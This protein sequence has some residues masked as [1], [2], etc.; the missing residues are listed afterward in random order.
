MNAPVGGQSAAAV[1]TGSHRITGSRRHWV[2]GGVL[3]AQFTTA[4][5]ATIVS[6]AAPT[7]ADDLR[8]VSLFGW[9]F[10]AYQLSSAIA[11]PVVGKLSDTYGRRPFYLAGMGCFLVGTMLCGGSMNMPELIGA[12][13][14][15]GVGGGTCLSLAATTVGDIFSPVERGR[16][17]GVISSGWGLGNVLGPLLGGFVTEHLGWRWVFF[18]TVAPGLVTLAI[19]LGWLP[20][21]RRSE[22]A[23]V[24]Y[25]GVALLTAGVVPL[26]LVLTWGGVEVPWTTPWLMALLAASLAV[27][28]IFCRHELRA[29]APIISPRLFSV[30]E[31]TL[32]VLLS[33]LAGTLLYSTIAF[34]PTY[35]QAV[36]GLGPQQAGALLTPFILSFV[37]GSGTAGQL[38]SRTGRYRVQLTT[39][40]V[41][42]LAGEL[43]M[44]VPPAPA[45]GTTVVASTLMGLGVGCTFPITNVVAQSTHPYRL[46]GTVNATRQFFTNLTGVL[47][48]SLMSTVLV[49]TL[50]N[51][52][53]RPL[54]PAA[55]NV[56]GGPGGL[57]TTAGGVLSSKGQ[58][59]LAARLAALPGGDGQAALEALRGGLAAGLQ[60]VF[61]ISTALSLAALAVALLVREIPLRR[62][63]D[64]P[65]GVP[66][67]STI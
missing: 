53:A 29:T 60:H 42:T 7:I 58:A 45:L 46:L 55:R 4:M 63:L 35:G 12:R 44:L 2:F 20:R 9:I 34:L 27:L 3:L 47:T 38:T 1:P 26:L 6:T 57:G 19:F 51:A 33:L 39:G 62:T 31:Y 59:E 50:A 22:P 25:A 14:L 30:R 24:D 10:T 36:M 52:L 54:P 67:P 49:N 41:L 18:I 16:W 23:K 64:E 43:L 21:F 13:L 11:I 65:A 40:I 56:L 5:T 48:I 17:L 66:P 8:G 28:A 37:L 32:M 61:E 15:A